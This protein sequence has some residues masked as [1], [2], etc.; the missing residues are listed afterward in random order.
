VRLVRDTNVLV[1]AFVSRGSCTELFE[2]CAR[3]HELFTSTFILDELAEKLVKKIGASQA[4][5]RAARRLVLAKSE[6]VEP[7]VVGRRVC[8]DP[9]DLPVLGT[10][11]AAH[12]RV[13]V[14]GDRDLLTIG[15]HAGVHILA[16][17]DFWRFEAS[18][19]KL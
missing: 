7:A 10:A 1:A 2:H 3:M 5:A 13:L 14:T 15:R 8:R 4:E 17:H 16:P 19:G 12:A 9:N 18:R 11:V 6:T